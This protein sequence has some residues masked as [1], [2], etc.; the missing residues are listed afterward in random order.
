MPCFSREY[1]FTYIVFETMSATHINYQVN[2]GLPREVVNIRCTEVYRGLAI[3]F[4]Q[5]IKRRRDLHLPSPKIKKYDLDDT[6]S[7]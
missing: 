7:V 3:S 2:Y 4:N 6:S 1:G 5:Q